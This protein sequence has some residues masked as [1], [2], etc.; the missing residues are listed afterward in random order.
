MLTKKVCN[1]CDVQML[2]PYKK[3]G[4]KYYCKRCAE[5]IECTKQ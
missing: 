4:N 1:G 3:I 5:E 2:Q